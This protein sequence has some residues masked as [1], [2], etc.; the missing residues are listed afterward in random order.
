MPEIG[1]N[2]APNAFSKIRMA[3]SEVRR[4][5][6]EDISQ[7]LNSMA[8]VKQESQFVDAKKHNKMDKDAFLKLLTFQLQNQDPLKPVDQKK[9]A[10]EL[11]QFSQLEQLTHMNQKLDNL[12][13]NANDETKFFGASFLGK[14]VTTRSTSIKY[15]GQG[16]RVELPFFLKKNARNAVLRILDS[17]N[18]LVQ[19]VPLE[20]LAKGNQSY[21][22]DGKSADKTVAAEGTYHFELKAFDE[23]LAPFNGETHAKGLVTGISFENGDTILEIDNGKKIFLRDVTQFSVPKNESNNLVKKEAITNYSKQ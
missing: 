15:S 17:K 4:D 18:Q 1:R 11:A 14:E 12:G 6:N 5:D 16:E 10:A 3:T 2:V 9:M 20:K 13:K 22:W 7:R 8:G 23:T 21:F 19:Q